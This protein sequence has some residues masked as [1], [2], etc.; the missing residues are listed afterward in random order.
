MGPFPKTWDRSFGASWATGKGGGVCRTRS[1][2]SS[3]TR[4]SRNGSSTT[5]STPARGSCPA[6][7]SATM[8]SRSNPQTSSTSTRAIP[9]EGGHALILAL[10]LMEPRSGQTLWLSQWPGGTTFQ[11][12][13]KESSRT[14]ASAGSM[15]VSNCAQ[16]PIFHNRD[17]STFTPTSVTSPPCGGR[18]LNIDS[19]SCPNGNNITANNFIAAAV[20]LIQDILSG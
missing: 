10:V 13:A 19:C 6:C 9:V 11:P 17:G 3:T 7:A 20:P 1:G 18:P 14:S 5:T 2:T 16:I 12:A 4:S 15:H 8:A